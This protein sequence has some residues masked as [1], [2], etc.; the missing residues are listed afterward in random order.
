MTIESLDSLLDVLEEFEDDAEIVFNKEDI[1][2]II[3]SLKHYIEYS[4]RLELSLLSN[5]RD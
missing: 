1:A 2:E 3:S 5:L 4:E